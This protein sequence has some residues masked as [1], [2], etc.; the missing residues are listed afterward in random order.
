MMRR[1]VTG[2]LWYWAVGLAVVCVH[3]NQER[4]TWKKLK[5]PQER[6]YTGVENPVTGPDRSVS[7][8]HCR[9]MQMVVSTGGSGGFL[10]EHPTTA[11]KMNNIGPGTVY[12]R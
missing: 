7:S 11:Q 5:S 2:H 12:A 10:V 4:N 6:E 9:G 3:G 1:L 8:G